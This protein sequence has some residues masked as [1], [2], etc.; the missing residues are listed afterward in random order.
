MILLC[1][2]KNNLCGNS[3][4]ADLLFFRFDKNRNGRVEL[5]ELENEIKNL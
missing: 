5:K 1:V 4:A 3:V 2:K